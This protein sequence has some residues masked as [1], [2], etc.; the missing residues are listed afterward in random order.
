MSRAIYGDPWRPWKTDRLM[1]KMVSD[2]PCMDN[3][4]LIVVSKTRK[5][6]ELAMELAFRHGFSARGW[7]IYK[8]DPNKPY[9]DFDPTHLLGVASDTFLVLSA[10]DHSNP[11]FHPFPLDIDCD[12]AIDFAWK[13]LEQQEYLNEPDHDGG[14]SKGFVMFNETWGNVDH[15]HSA[16]CAI[17]P[18]WAM[19]GK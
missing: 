10:W 18:A 14:N 16:I 4:R 15:D 13:W 5:D 11:N 6:F 9:N 12:S 3:N 2:R 19:H 7:W 1:E 8:F 17:G